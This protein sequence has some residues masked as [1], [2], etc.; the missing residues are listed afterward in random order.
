MSLCVIGKNM[1]NFYYILSF[2]KLSICNSLN[3]YFSPAGDNFRYLP[4]FFVFCVIFY[5]G[6]FHAFSLYFTEGLWPFVCLVCNFLY[7]S[8]IPIVFA[9]IWISLLFLGYYE[10]CSGVPD[11]FFGGKHLLFSLF[12]KNAGWWGNNSALVF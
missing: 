5:T 6:R 7:F 8:K 3:L 12:C 4:K 10:E 1:V 9:L 2:M 11:D